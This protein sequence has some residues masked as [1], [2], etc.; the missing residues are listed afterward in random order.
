M[1]K[2]GECCMPS[3]VAREAP[4]D[5]QSCH[6]GPLRLAPLLSRLR[7]PAPA[8]LAC[9]SE[10]PGGP[11]AMQHIAD[12]DEGLERAAPGFFREAWAWDPRP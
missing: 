9:R 11:A 5:E 8:G 2:H 3:G 4:R 7:Q 10:P 6:P 12:E 1:S